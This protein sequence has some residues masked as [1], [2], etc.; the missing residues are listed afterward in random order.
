MNS[1][2]LTTL[3]F[4]TLLT[5]SFGLLSSPDQSTKFFE[6]ASKGQYPDMVDQAKKGLIS[7]ND[8]YLERNADDATLITAAIK[9]FPQA[10]EKYGEREATEYL[11][12]ILDRLLTK[13]PKE[14]AAEELLNLKDNNGMTALF[15][16]A[17]NELKKAAT[18]LHSKGAVP[19]IPGGKK[20]S[21]YA[22]SKKMTVIFESWE[23]Y[24]LENVETVSE[25]FASAGATMKGG[26]TGVTP[27][28]SLEEKIRRLKAQRTTP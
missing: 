19:I 4:G 7:T 12:T 2:F 18:V 11:N 16:A 22:T 6:F 8:L 9:A 23:K 24:Q 15:Y 3:M 28:E 17:Q 1:K 21:D 14:R 13:L 27:D 5:T 10:S 26:F 25:K 20:A